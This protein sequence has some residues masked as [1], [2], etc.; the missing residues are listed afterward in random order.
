VDEVLTSVQKTEE[1][2]RRLKNLREKS[3]QPSATGA[4]EKQLMSDDD[5]IRLQLQID[6][7]QYVSCI[8]KSQLKR[9]EVDSLTALVNLI[10]DLSKMKITV[11]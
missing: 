4:S 3:Q 9:D 2:L 8:E 5:K 10:G 11:G 1:S 6:V 7:M